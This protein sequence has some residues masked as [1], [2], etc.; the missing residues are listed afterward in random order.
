LATARE[1]RQ[2]GHDVT[3]LLGGRDVEESSIDGWDGAVV[4]IEAARFPGRKILKYPGFAL[5]LIRAIFSVYRLFRQTRPAAVLAMG[6]YTSLAP[7]AAAKLCGAAVVLH[8]ANAVPGQAVAVLSRFATV[9]GLNFPQAADCIRHCR[10]EVVGLPLRAGMQ[11]SEHARRML[12]TLLVMGGSQGARAINE[13]IPAALRIMKQRGLELDVIHLAG[14]SN[15]ADVDRVYRDSGIA[16]D[17]RDF[18]SDMSSV[19]TAADFAIARAGAASCT[20]L[21]ACGV[22]ALLIPHPTVPGDHQTK[23]AQAMV[24]SGGFDMRRQ[25]ELSSEWLAGY[26]E[27]IVV[28]PGIVVN[29]RNQL[30][31]TEVV[32]GA[33]RLADLV[34]QA[35]GR[36]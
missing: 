13:V 14:K 12:S 29:M 35:C 25:S 34:E 15:A 5:R 16:A 21:A 30:L 26:L 18:V 9:T 24:E 20:E 3:L 36:S 32:D 6:S 1:L 7:V 19:Y 17:V 27:N 8:E 33:S 28:N 22:P 31:K 10:T 23:N 11:R 4:S 2:R